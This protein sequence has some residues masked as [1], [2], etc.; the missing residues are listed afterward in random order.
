MQ[1]SELQKL[2]YQLYFHNDSRRGAKA[3]YDW[4]K[5]EVRELGEALEERNGAIEKE[6]AD[7]IAWLASLA[8]VVGIDL[9]KAVL[10]K[11]AGKCPKCGSMPC[12]CP[13]RR[14]PTSVSAPDQ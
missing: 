8:N 10:G 14:S 6:F 5:D 7:V 13:F 9:E 2:M 12:K 11:Y 4:L 1:I 3:T